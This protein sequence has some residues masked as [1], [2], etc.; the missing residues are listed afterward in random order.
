MCWVGL[1]IE[2]VVVDLVF[3]DFLLFEVGDCILVDV[4][5]FVVYLVEVVEV[6]LIGELYVVVKIL[7][8]VFESI[9]LVECSNMVFM[10]IVVMCGWLEVVVIV[11][12][13]NIEMGYLVDLLVEIVELVMLL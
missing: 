5:V 2:I 9:I 12:G 11:I 6:V 1:V 13:M 7:V 4:C 10:N 8:V 3:G